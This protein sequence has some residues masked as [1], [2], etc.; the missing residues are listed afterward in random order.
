MSHA[1]RNFDGIGTHFQQKIYNSPKGVIRLRVLEADFTQHLPQLKH[2]PTTILDAGCGAANFS[3]QLAQ[4]GHRMVLCDLSA[5]MIEA[6]ENT[7]SDHGVTGTF[8]QS[9]IQQFPTQSDE[10]YRMILNHAVLEWCDAPRSVLESLVSL[11]APG[12]MLSLMFYNLHGIRLRNLVR[13]NLKKVKSN[14][15][16]GEPGSLTPLHPLEPT[17]VLGW[18]DQ[19]GMELIAHS[20]VRTYFDLM[21]RSSRDKIPLED[22]IELELALR[23]QPPY[24]DMG[25]YIHLICRKTD[26]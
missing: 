2:Q 3:V 24:R 17:E 16:K 13:G 20:G 12:G 6:A 14:R 1:D 10:S 9:S 8:L 19:L 22:I 5:E 15:F 11:L 23:H 4:Q 18:L 21:D 26:R 25:R 7:F